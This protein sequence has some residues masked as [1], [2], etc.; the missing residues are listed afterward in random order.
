MGARL[1]RGQGERGAAALEMAFVAPFLLLLILGVV[2]FG[3]KFGQFN[4]IRHAAREGARFAA[5]NAG[6]S[7]AIR[8]HVC[9]ALDAVDAGIT[10]VDIT[11]NEGSGLQGGTGSIRVVA[12]V[13]SISAAPLISVFLP[14]QL[15]SEVDFRLEQDA[16]SWASAV[17]SDACP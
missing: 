6:D 7:D 16:D 14:A 9:A 8:D 1:F 17:Y 4:D 12:H 3:W 15:A 5:V 13:D 2:E 10:Q 11:L